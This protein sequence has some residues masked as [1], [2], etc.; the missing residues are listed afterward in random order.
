MLG[1]PWRGTHG[2]AR[3]F[4]FVALDRFVWIGAAMEDEDLAILR[5]LGGDHQIERK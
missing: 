2:M 4:S 3:S 5:W 1:E